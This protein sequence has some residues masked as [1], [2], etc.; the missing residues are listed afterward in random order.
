MEMIGELPVEKLRNV[1]DPMVIG[2][3]TSEEMKPLDIIIGQERAVRSLQF[4]LGIKELGFNIYVAGLPGTG[5]TTAVKRF[6]EEEAK[7]QP[8]PRDWCYVNNFRDPYRP[9]ALSLP[10]GRA[11][12]LQTDMRGL[13]E[14]TRQEIRKAF[15]SDEYAARREETIKA[16]QRQRDELFAR[17]NER[18]QKEGF[19]IQATPIGLLTIPM[20]EGKPLSDEE[21]RALSPEARKEISKKREMLQVELKT[22]I[23]QARGL[24]KSANEELQKL[25]REVALYALG[26]LIEDLKEK[27]QDLPE[28]VA[29]LE[30][31]REDILENLSQFRA[32][33]QAQPPFPLPGARE[34][35]FR[36]YEVNVL[37]DNSEL[38]GAPVVM[39]LNPTYNNLFGRI[40]KEA[41]FGA[42]VTDFTL[43]RPGS[44]HRAN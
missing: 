28:V 27:Y 22:A 38:E 5:R 13:V 37:V 15:E 29:Y 11:K 25:D 18:A 6:L 39:E 34:L 43:I 33:P 24:E 42:L 32:E 30:E 1:C 8:V 3:E 16:F 19:L 14:G 36:K 21:F 17:I 26:P 4:G 9:K 20:V 40:E 23:R 7:D 10:P 44:L 41:Q 12:E 2:C 31:V 35:P